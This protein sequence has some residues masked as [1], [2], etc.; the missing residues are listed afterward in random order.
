[1]QQ[2]WRDLCSYTKHQL[3]SLASS[4]YSL[5]GELCSTSHI[6]NRRRNNVIGRGVQNDTHFRADTY[7][8]SY[9]FGQKKS[10]VDIRQI[11]QIQD[12]P[13]CSQHFARFC[14]S[15]LNT[16]IT[17]RS[18]LAIPNFCFDAIDGGCGS[19]YG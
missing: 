16:T 6:G 1:M 3:L 8:T 11:N 9:R 18:Q 4:F 19:G 10:H 15:Y 2:L 13:T 17:W 12:P 5:G 7:A 14:H